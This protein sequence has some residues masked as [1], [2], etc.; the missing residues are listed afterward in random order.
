[1]QRA[2]RLRARRHR[3]TFVGT[4]G[5]ETP[6]HYPQ[7]FRSRA[8]PWPR[9]QASFI[10]DLQTW[11]CA[12]AYTDSAPVSRDGKTRDSCCHAPRN[13]APSERCETIR[14]TAITTRFCDAARSTNAPEVRFLINRGHWLNGSGCPLC[15]TSGHSGHCSI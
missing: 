4:C 7:G 15:A 9:I 1:M 2:K 10:F 6:W 12:K 13:G 3:L 11:L 14:E 5:A 8:G